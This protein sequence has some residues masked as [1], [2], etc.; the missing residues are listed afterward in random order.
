MLTLSNYNRIILPLWL[1][2]N[3][4]FNFSW[5]AFYPYMGYLVLVVN[6]LALVSFYSISSDVFFVAFA[7]FALILLYFLVP[8]YYG[9]PN[10]TNVLYFFSF[11]FACFYYNNVIVKYKYYF[12]RFLWFLFIMSVIQELLIYFDFN[13]PNQ[14]IENARQIFTLYRPFYVDREN[15]V[16]SGLDLFLIGQRFHGPFFEPGNA[17]FAAFVLFISSEKKIWKLISVIFGILTMSMFFIVLTTIF[18]LFTNLTRIQINKLLVAVGVFA[19]IIFILI[20]FKD[21][22]I[23]AST[24][25]RILGEGDKVL[26]TRNTVFE[27]DQ[28]MLF[29]ES[30]R[31]LDTRLFFGL[32][33]DLPGSG[34]SYRQWV[35]STGLLFNFLLFTIGFFYVTKKKQLKKTLLMFLLLLP[36]FYTRGYWF[37]INICILGAAVSRDF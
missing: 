8:R 31:T 6:L 35:L 28:I 3:A 27:V 25:G 37:D 29:Q 11:I 2:V 22:F 12:I 19:G 13:L 7:A 5:I 15:I 21:S 1:I 17:G 4:L 36:F 9:P 34:G 10:V 16:K 26:N 23:Y 18:V 24:I 20:S 30:F 33:F 32:G 14:R